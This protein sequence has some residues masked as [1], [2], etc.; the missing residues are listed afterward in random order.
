MLAVLGLLGLAGIAAVLLVGRGGGSSPFDGYVYV[1]SNR[2]TPGRNS[3][4]AFGFRNGRFRLVGEYPTGGA[5]AID[6]GETGALDA[7]GQIA[8]DLE[9]RLL[10]AVNQGSDTVAVFRVRPDGRLAAVRGSPFPAGGKAPA[11]VAVA[12]GFL[13]VVAKAHDARRALER[14]TPK[15]VPFRIRGDGGLTP[16]GSAFAA[17][18]ASSPTQALAVTERLVV[19]TE[20]SGPFRAFVVGGD[21]SLLQAA[22]SP[23]EPEA[24]IFPPRYEGARWAIGIVRHPTERLLYANQPAIEKLLVYSYEETG[25]LTFVAAVGNKGSK[26][27]CWTAVT[28]DGRGLYTANAGNGTISAFD[29]RD[30]RSPRQLQTFALRRGGNPWGLSLDP[31]GRTLFVVDPR[32]VPAVPH[33]R[34]NRLHALAVGSEGRLTQ[35]ASVRLPV[36]DDASPLGIAVAPRA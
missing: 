20:E 17:P 18:P 6:P 11:S 19:G 29:L 22:N 14:V 2:A 31:G 27:P 12:G 21:G 30:P 16:A 4:L 8:I 24:S 15:Y 25:R 13:V 32:A 26:L 9:R 35:I 28:P 34:G 33:G 5:G 1:Q 7:D 36:G 23:L 10:F 3:V